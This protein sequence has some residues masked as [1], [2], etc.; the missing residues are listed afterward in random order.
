MPATWL[1]R[2]I[3]MV[4]PRWALSRIRARAVAEVLARHYDAASSGRRTEGWRRASGDA[5][6]VIGPALG[7]LRDAS[8]DLVRNNPYAE[9]AVRTIVNEAIGW[10]LVAKPAPADPRA[11]TAWRAW[12]ETTACDADGRHDFYGL[13][14]LVMR[15]VVVRGEAIVR[16]RVRRPEDGL[17]IPV[18]LQV[19]DPDYLDL[20]KDGI[21]LPNGGRIVQGVEFDPI[22]RRAGYWL[23]K[24]HPGASLASL[25]PSAR[26]PAEFVAHVFRQ[27]RPG[28]VRGVPW[29]APVL[30]RHRDFDD[31]E[32]AQLMKQKVA[33]CLAVIKSDPTGTLDPIGEPRD[34]NVDMLEP[35]AILN[36]APD[37]NIQVVSPPRVDGYAEYSETVLRAIA[38]GW[39]VTFEDMTGSYRELPFSAARMSRVQ[40]W[41]N[42]EDWRW[43]MLIPQFCDVA[44]AWAMQAAIIA[45]Q[46]RGAAPAA[47]WTGAPAPMVDPAAEGL[48]IQRN[49]RTG[50]QTLYDALRERGISD[51]VDHLREMAEANGLLDRYGIVLDSD[52]RKM[53][54]AGQLQGA[55]SSAAPAAASGRFSNVA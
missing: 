51:P 39:G 4:A 1:D 7:R 48:A 9:A 29:A 46:V 27:Q 22:G 18:Q 50:I 13:Q 34:P 11:A 26:I 15:T 23:F 30:L 45:G 31:L 52:P 8:E 19:L 10:G 42:V 32:D 20:G 43:R 6:A 53:T 37:S 55:A 12:A 49:I 33:A 3:A 38:A 2:S 47:V 36:V 54:Q 5:N 14:K 16:L 28:Q 24:D 44:W 35:G 25:T 41:P 17:P 40:H 21:A